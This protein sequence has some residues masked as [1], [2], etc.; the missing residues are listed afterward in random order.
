MDRC[1]VLRSDIRAGKFIVLE[2]NRR[3]LAAKLLKNPAL[4]NTLDMPEAFK[5]RLLKASQGFDVKKIE[6]VDCYE[7]ADRAEGNDWIRQRHNGADEGRGIVNWSAIAGSRFRGRDPA[8]QALDFVM[9]HGELTDEQ[10]EKIASISRETEE[11]MGGLAAGGNP[12]GALK[13]YVKLREIAM[14]KI[15]AVLTPAQQDKW[16]AMLGEPFKG[17]IVPSAELGGGGRA[18]GGG[19]SN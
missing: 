15:V 16:K 2:G 5:K 3:L 4:I 7:V 9:E 10:K 11:S 19:N 14:E 18:P 17:E 6:P 1:L 13:E 8:L 12:D